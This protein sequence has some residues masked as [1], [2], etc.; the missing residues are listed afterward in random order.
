MEQGRKH[1]HPYCARV[2][3]RK[4]RYR[5]SL[6]GGGAA[7]WDGVEIVFGARWVAIVNR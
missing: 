6:A 2:G 3:S 7:I 4:A 5:R 1:A